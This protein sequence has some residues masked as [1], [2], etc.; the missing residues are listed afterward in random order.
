[1]LDGKG[2]DG[3]GVRRRKAL[4]E[5]S[6]TTEELF[7]LF[8]GRGFGPGRHAGRVAS[9]ASKYDWHGLLQSV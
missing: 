8:F 2:D 5:L 7:G 3:I 6:I 1:M 9:G 4:A